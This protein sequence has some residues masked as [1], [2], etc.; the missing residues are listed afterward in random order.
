[1]ILKP[2]YLLFVNFV[3]SILGFSFEF[4]LKFWDVSPAVCFVLPC[5]FVQVVLI[6]IFTFPSFRREA[7]T[8]HYGRAKE[9]VFYKK[10]LSDEIILLSNFGTSSPLGISFG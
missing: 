5:F 6:L 7:F 4:G 8:E 10:F 2:H 1:M 9:M 3:F